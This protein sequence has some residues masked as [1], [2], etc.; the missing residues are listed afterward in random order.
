MCP[1]GTRSWAPEL[2]RGPAQTSRGPQGWA[3]QG[4]WAAGQEEEPGSAREAFRR[5]GDR[6]RAESGGGRPHPFPSSPR[7]PCHGLFC[8]RGRES[9]LG[10]FSSREAAEAGKEGL[11]GGL[12]RPFQ[13]PASFSLHAS[14][15]SS[16]EQAVHVCPQADG[17][18]VEPPPPPGKL[19]ETP[20][21]LC[22]RCR[23]RAAGE[24]SRKRLSK[25][26]RRALRPPLP[27][28][29]PQVQRGDRQAA[30]QSASA[31]GTQTQ[32]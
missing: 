9:P 32:Y 10:G 23:G 21:L 8:Q 25:P 26:S 18:P 27:E 2:S 11:G 28:E 16:S 17:R 13:A 12:G 4:R 22:A 15:L 5:H 30:G 19:C 20:H 7:S 14:Q 1:A 31:P 6:W 3:G 24:V 29:T